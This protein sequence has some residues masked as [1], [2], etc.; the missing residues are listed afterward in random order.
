VCFDEMPR[1]TSSVEMAVVSVDRFHRGGAV[2]EDEIHGVDSFFAIAAI[3]HV[4]SDMSLVDGIFA[5]DESL[6]SAPGWAQHFYDCYPNQS[7]PKGPDEL[8]DCYRFADL[9]APA[10]DDW[11]CCSR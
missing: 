11:K 8:H 4:E 3:A 5:D 7:L 2:C 10:K 1:F 6:K 9:A